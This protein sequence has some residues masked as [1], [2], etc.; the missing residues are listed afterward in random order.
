MPLETFINP[1]FNLTFP[2]LYELDG[3]QKVNQHFEL[4]LTEKN[5]QL[6]KDFALLKESQKENSEILIAVAKIFEEFLAELFLITKETKILKEK[7]QNLAIIYRIK[8]DFIQRQIA[9]K[10]DGNSLNDDFDGIEILQKLEIKYDDIDELEI[11][12]S[13][14]IANEENLEDLE[15]YAIWALFKKAGKIFHQDGSLFILPQKLDYNNLVQKNPKPKER[16]DFNLCDNGFGLN[17]SLSEANYCIF[18]HN[19][20]KDSCKTGLIDK[21]TNHIKTNPLGVD[22]LG[23]PM[24][25]KISEMNLLK[26]Q[27]FSIGS[28]AMAMV[29][30]PLI[31]STGH[32]I[33]NDCMKSCIYQKQDPVDIP[34]VETRILKDVLAL[35]YGFEIYSLLTRFNPLNIKNNLPKANSGKKVL[36]CGLGPAGF[37][38][39]NYLLQLGHEVT[40][41][42]GLKIEPLN[43]NISG[44]DEFKNRVAFKPIKYLDEIYEPL[45]SRQIGGFGGVAE[46][47]ITVRWDKNF[48]KIIRLTLERRKNFTM[49]GGLR[50]GSS[51]NDVQAFNDYGFDHIALCLGAG[52]PNI[53]DLKNNFAKG[54]RLASDFLMSLQLTGAFKEELFTNLQIKTPIIVI[55]GGLTATDTACEANLYYIVQIR[56]FADKLAKIGKEKI[57]N[58]LNEE[59]K[60]IAQEFLDH[61]EIYQ[62]QGLKALFKKIG[63]TKI[64]YRKTLIE[65]PAYRLNHQEINSALEQGI[66]FIENITPKEVVIDEFN[67]IKSIKCLKN[68]DEELEFNCGSL[69]IGAGTTPNISAVLEDGLNFK[70]SGKYFSHIKDRSFI[71]KISQETN[72]SVSFLGDLHPDFEG[73]VVKALAS[74]KLASKEIDENLEKVKSDSNNNFKQK[75]IDEFLVKI[76]EVTRLSDHVLEVSIKAPLLAK[77]SQIGHIFRLQN[78]HFFAKEANGQKLA[79][80]GVALTAIDI[81]KKLG[82]ITGIIVETGGSASLIQNFK[83][84]EPCI[85]MGPSGTPTEFSTNETV[86]LI[87]GGRGNQVLSKIAKIFKNR[88]C[89]VLLFAGYKNSKFIVRENEMNANSD[90]LI[91]S[92]EE[93]ENDKYFKGLVTESL[94]DYFTKNPN[95]IDRIFT[96][97]NNK[98]MHEIAKI[99][100]QNLV[101]SISEAKI[102]IT[103]LNSP[104]QCMMKGVCSQ[105]LQR[106][107]NDDGKEEY[108]YSCSKQDQNM[109]GFDFDFLHK[110]CEQNSL[111]E[112]T[113]K[114]WINFLT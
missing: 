11:K 78:Y 108:F 21:Q 24:D 71:T 40:A 104:M 96:I 81:D 16:H 77:S 74:G 110:R 61:F 28:L 86:L 34:Q 48:L 7:H 59:E 73:N 4:F 82:I 85:F 15:K 87:G 114:M 100:H 109:E 66:E 53:I 17:R 76:H 106:K 43:S 55:G 93:G 60:I 3:L 46:Y 47:G 52:R 14:K 23:C 38:L 92:V 45:N 102:A 27:A 95:K 22:L 25:E 44:I 101:S 31:A 111:A 83:K 98:M 18:C 10:Y 41:I 107:I 12:L 65:S 39:A 57:W 69:L 33:C 88:N 30:N 49:F 35:P 70:L 56:K 36:I 62:K 89:K 29:D 80:E 54:V 75:I 97:G 50:F 112:K 42:D 72:K 94:I 8:R 84:D 6:A 113:S 51:I 1:K 63:T 67:H 90:K 99:K 26:S 19:Q 2:D 68:E 5:P 79:M 13:Q 64:L 103:S 32:R 37:S 9:K 105:C 20:E 91:I 58:I